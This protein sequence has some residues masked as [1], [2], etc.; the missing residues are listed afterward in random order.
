MRR[1]RGASNRLARDVAKRVEVYRPASLL[2]IGVGGADLFSA[3]CKGHPECRVE[4][5]APERVLE[6]LNR[7]G[8]YDLAFVSE[9]LEHLP[10]DAAGVLL[11]S[12]RDL[13]A[14]ALL[15]LVSLGHAG[16]GTRWRDA[17]LLGY[18]LERIG[19]YL[20]QGQRLAL[21]RFDLYDYKTPPD[22]LNSQYWAHP[23]LW[24][25]HRW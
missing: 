4:T 1:E 11:G 12:V 3:Y 14:K 13:H 24:G 6:G 2:L 8:R 9:T 18:G 22:W 25:K 10:S 5:L 17:D 20:V 16:Y 7:L 19:E 21:Y 15:V 23:E